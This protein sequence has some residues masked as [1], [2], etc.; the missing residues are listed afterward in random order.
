VRDPTG[1]RSY[2]I[3]VMD[4]RGKLVTQ[5]KHFVGTRREAHKQCRALHQEWAS[6][7]SG[8]GVTVVERDPKS[9]D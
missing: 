2:E 5:L 4:A 3:R 9:F 1:I 8:V 6:R 7:R